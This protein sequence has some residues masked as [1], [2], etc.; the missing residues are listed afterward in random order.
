M[1]RS[2]DIVYLR[3]DKP[4]LIHVGDTSLKN[5][6]LQITTFVCHCLLASCDKIRISFEV[7]V[8]IM[9]YSENFHGILYVHGFVYPF[10]LMSVNSPFD[11]TT[12]SSLKLIMIFLSWMVN[13]FLFPCVK[14]EFLLNGFVFLDSDNTTTKK[15]TF[16]LY[17]PHSKSTEW[18]ENTWNYKYGYIRSTRYLK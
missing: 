10:L 18:K 2:N 8:L 1:F 5:H 15:Y 7:D 11:V 13:L 9:I 6:S 12:P 3:I 17:V 14:S 4:I 16:Q